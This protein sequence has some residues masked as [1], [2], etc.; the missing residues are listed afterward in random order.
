MLLLDNRKAFRRHVCAV[1]RPSVRPG[2]RRLTR[3]EI[4]VV[5]VV[6]VVRHQL[7][8]VVAVT[9]ILPAVHRRSAVKR[10]VGVTRRCTAVS[11]V[12]IRRRLSIVVVIVDR[13]RPRSRSLTVRDRLDDMTRRLVVLDDRF[14]FLLQ[15]RSHIVQQTSLSATHA[16]LVL[17]TD[18]IHQ[19]RDYLCINEQQAPHKK[20]RTLQCK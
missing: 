7:N 9:T 14:N 5:I 16:D 11:C 12:T 2:Y 4:P 18:L 15:V 20:P 8:R 19:T 6:I 13:V 17:R 3:P 10:Y 1:P